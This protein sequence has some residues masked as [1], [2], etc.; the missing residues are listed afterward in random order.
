MVKVLEKKRIEGSSSKLARKLQQTKPLPDKISKDVP[1]TQVSGRSI[2]GSKSSKA[3]GTGY[4]HAA[5]M[6]EYNQR[7][8]VIARRKKYY[9]KRYRNHREEI[10]ERQRTNAKKRK[11]KLKRKEYR[12]RPEVKLRERER[13]SNISEEEKQRRL[14]RAR[15]RS[16]TPESTQ[17]RKKYRKSK[18]CKRLEK[19]RRKTDKHK[20]TVRTY[21]GKSEVKERRKQLWQSDKYKNQQKVYRQRPEVKEKRR[22]YRIMLRECKQ[23]IKQLDSTDLAV[24]ETA[25]FSLASRKFKPA[26]IPLLKLLDKREHVIRCAAVYALG[27]LRVVDTLDKLIFEA[28]MASVRG[29][30]IY[31]KELFTALSKIGG[32]KASAAIRRY[33]LNGVSVPTNHIKK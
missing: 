12:Q 32:S 17:K 24:V 3:N 29:D 30:S 1:G 2:G 28:R 31:L 16:R 14:E 5:Y 23:F 19:A 8:E 20:D 25:I 4:D 15:E 9:K 7:P 22:K 13:R 6:R 26:H 21:R 11:A 10:L 27:E 33:S 18:R